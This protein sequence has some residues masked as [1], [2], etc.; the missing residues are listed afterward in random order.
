MSTQSFDD[1]FIIGEVASSLSYRLWW[2]RTMMQPIYL[3]DH[4]YL[5]S[6]HS[7]GSTWRL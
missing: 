1:V 5:L 7:L 2:K 6:L 4:S 3:S